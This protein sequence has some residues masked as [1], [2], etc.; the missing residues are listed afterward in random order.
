MKKTYLIGA[1]MLML[2]ILSVYGC[3]ST[4]TIIQ[5]APSSTYTPTTTIPTWTGANQVINSASWELLPSNGVNV[6]AGKTLSLSWSAD[7]D[8]KCYICTANQYNNFKNS[9]GVSINYFQKG[10]GSQGSISYTVQNTDTYYAILY[11]D[12]LGF[13][14]VGPTVNLYQAILT[15]H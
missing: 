6:Q 10:E 8:L 15:E 1:V 3:G 9:N 7:G 11:N 13:L 12:A 5:Q 14:G 2:I 4:T